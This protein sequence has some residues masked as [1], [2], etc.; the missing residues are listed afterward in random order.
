MSVNNDISL[1]V[2]T[3]LLAQR[4]VAL[5]NTAHTAIYPAAVTSPQI[6]ITM[7]TVLDT[8]G[9]IPVRVSGI[10]KVYMNDTCAAGDLI[11]GDSS[12]YGKKHVDTTA[13]SYVVGKALEA[14]AATG[15]VIQ[16]LIQPHFKSIP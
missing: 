3:T 2:L 5:N 10:A 8:T 11:A 4:I 9:A 7:D 14:S 13:G 12:G 15:T 16:V 1:K 6:G